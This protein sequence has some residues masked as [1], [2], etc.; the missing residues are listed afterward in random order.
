MKKPL[1]SSIFYSFATFSLLTLCLNSQELPKKRQALNS[2]TEQNNAL[3]AIK[4]NNSKEYERLNKLRKEDEKKFK[5]ELEK[6]YFAHIHTQELHKNRKNRPL[7]YRELKKENEIK[8]KKL[9]K[10]YIEASS[11]KEKE[12]VK[13]KIKVVGEELHKIELDF[14]IMQFKQAKEFIKQ[15]ELELKNFEKNKDYFIKRL[16]K[17]ITN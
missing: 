17:K 1:Y 14:K 10:E 15:K 5:T 6:A 4:N 3:F 9:K 12:L 7:G 13:E 2:K 8:I 11:T 16:I